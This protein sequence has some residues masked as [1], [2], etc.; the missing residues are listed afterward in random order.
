ML[1]QVEDAHARHAAVS[2]ECHRSDDQ[3][4]ERAEAPAVAEAG[5]VKA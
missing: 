5:M 2:F 3:S 1:V 4:V